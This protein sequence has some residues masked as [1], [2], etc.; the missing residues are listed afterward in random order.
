M[1]PTI[2][3]IFNRYMIV[4]LDDKVTRKI[5]LSEKD[6]GTT[7]SFEALIRRIKN[8]V[9]SDESDDEKIKDKD[10]EDEDVLVTIKPT[11]ALIYR[12]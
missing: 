4:G 11:D 7:E 2:E 8:T 5:I 12:L 6:Q 10:D 1:E 3:K 9:I